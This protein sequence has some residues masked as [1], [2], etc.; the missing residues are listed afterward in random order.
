VDTALRPVLRGGAQE[1]SELASIGVKL[2]SNGWASVNLKF[3]RC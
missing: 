1:V 3:Q 2:S